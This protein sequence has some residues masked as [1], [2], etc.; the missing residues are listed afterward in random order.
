MYTVEYTKKNYKSN[1]YSN[2]FSFTAPAH[3]PLYNEFSE[4]TESLQLFGECWVMNNE[5]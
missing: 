3:W 2:F 1:V 5:H 4:E